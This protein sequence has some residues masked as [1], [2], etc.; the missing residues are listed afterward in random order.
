MIDETL[1]MIPAPRSAPDTVWEAVRDDYLA[2]MSAVDCCRAHGVGRTA[3][4]DRAAREGWRR[5]DQVWLPARLEA[6]DPGVTLEEQIGGD[7]DKVDYAELSGVA[8]K[9]MMRAVLRGDA[10][11]ALRWRRVELV[12]D[13]KQAEVD[14]FLARDDTSVRNRREQVELDD[15]LRDRAEAQG[16]TA[17]DPD[18]PDSPDSVFESGSEP[19]APASPDL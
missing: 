14:A 3:L 6:G 1:T 7:L 18:S 10:A 4:R 2:G 13:A 19:W 16:W 5:R 8:V 17:P 9:R 15:Y 12:M 11:A